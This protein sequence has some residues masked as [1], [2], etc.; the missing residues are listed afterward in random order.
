MSEYGCLL[1]LGRCGD[2]GSVGE[3]GF[4]S[5]KTRKVGR[6]PLALPFG[7]RRKQAELERGDFAPGRRLIVLIPDADLPKRLVAGFQWCA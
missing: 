7:G 5:V 1:G 4:G 2:P 3:H 6:N